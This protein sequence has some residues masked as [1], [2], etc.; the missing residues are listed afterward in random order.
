MNNCPTYVLLHPSR[1]VDVT[2]NLDVSSDVQKDTFPERVDQIGSRRGL[3]F[4][5][6]HGIKASS[7]ANDPDCFQRPLCADLRRDAHR[8]ARENEGVVW[9]YSHEPVGAD[10]YYG[11]HNGVYAAVAE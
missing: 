2:I 5:K 7:D 11:V 1:S 8:P 4:S 9:Q 10:V 6:R 3:K